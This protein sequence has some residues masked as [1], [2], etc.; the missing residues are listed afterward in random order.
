[1]TVPV[2][3]KEEGGYSVEIAPRCF[4]KWHIEQ[5]PQGNVMVIEVVAPAVTHYARVDKVNDKI[6]LPLR[7]LPQ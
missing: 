2:V 3:K 5:K 6:E 1:M 7:C 4:L